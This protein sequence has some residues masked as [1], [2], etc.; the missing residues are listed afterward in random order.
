MSN[1]SQEYLLIT[2]E[3]IESL[4]KTLRHPQ[5][6]Y[7]PDQSE[8]DTMNNLKAFDPKRYN[9]IMI[10]L[11]IFPLTLNPLLKLLNILNE[12]LYPW[13]LHILHTTNSIIKERAKHQE[14]IPMIPSSEI[15]FYKTIVLPTITT[16][17]LSNEQLSRIMLDNP[18]TLFKGLTEDDFDNRS[19][20]EKADP[21]F[22]DAISQ[23]TY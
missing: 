21:D 7:R 2:A 9:F 5:V 6:L 20:N 13:L 23:I 4:V 14:P 18:D 17:K 1:L 10:L 12:N 22:F 19:A 16:T 15:P 3:V 11:R 8:I